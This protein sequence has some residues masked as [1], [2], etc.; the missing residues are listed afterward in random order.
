MAER[1]IRAGYYRRYDGK[2][3]YVVSLSTDADTEV[4]SGP[5]IPSRMFPSTTPPAKSPSALLSK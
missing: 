4:S 5:P 2:V 3:V 1:K